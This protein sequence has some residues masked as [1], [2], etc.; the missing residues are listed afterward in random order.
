MFGGVWTQLW[1]SLLLEISMEPSFLHQCTFK[2]RASVE[3]TRAQTHTRTP[4]DIAKHLIGHYWRRWHEKIELDTLVSPL[5]S[6]LISH[7]IPIP[8]AHSWAYAP[9]GWWHDI[10]EYIRTE[11]ELARVVKYP[12]MIM[13]RHPQHASLLTPNSYSISSRCH[14]SLFHFLRPELMSRIRI[15]EYVFTF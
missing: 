4:L 1:S 10:L 9:S 6:R 8:Q 11:Y 5:T 3:S 14:C 7:H 2:N 12:C 15:Y 13:V